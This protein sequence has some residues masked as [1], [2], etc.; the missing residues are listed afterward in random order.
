MRWR[1]RRQ[2]GCALG[3][4]CGCLL[5]F[6]IWALVIGIFAL[7]LNVIKDSEP[8]QG[9]LTQ[10]R[11]NERVIEVLGEPIEPGWWITGS[12][13]T[14]DTSGFADFAFPISGPDNS[15]NLYVVALK[16]AGEWEFQRIE[17]EIEGQSSRIRLL[18][19]R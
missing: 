3:G 15:G 6:G 14:T 9:A 10:A 18:T 13:E 4:G 19:G 2:S 11:S 12:S 7:V 17:L 1:W 8:Y 5:F 16:S